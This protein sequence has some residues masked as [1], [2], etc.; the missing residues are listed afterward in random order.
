ME[1]LNSPPVA[2]LLVA[3]V[4]AVV[5]KASFLFTIPPG[6]VSPIFPAAG[7]AIAAVLILGRNALVGVWLGSFAAN[8][9]SFFDGTVSP[10]HAVLPTLLVASFIG[11]GNM[12]GAGAGAFLVRRFC[13][14]EYPLRSGRNVLMLVTV[15]ALGC[16]M[17]NATFGVLSL[18]LGCFVPWERFGYSWITWWMGDATGAI[19][20]APLILAWHH[21]HP[22]HKNLWR[23]T[24][25]A[26]LG[27]VTLLLG[28]FVFFRNMPFAYGLMPL[29]LWAAFRFGMRGASTAAAAIAIFATI[30]TSCGGSPFVR[31]TVNE[32]LLFLHSFLDVT[33]I[34]ALFLAGVLA[35]RKRAEEALRR[36]EATLH[37]VFQSTPVGICIMK[38]RLFQSANVCW[39]ECFGY[40][41]KSILGK[42]TRMLYESDEEYDRVGQALY[43][44]LREGSLAT[45]E[46]RLRRSDG[47]LR[48]VV[49]TAALLRA[50]D[51]AAGIVVTVHDVTNRKRMEESLRKSE[52]QFRLI[53][54]N[55]ADL[56]AV[57]DLNGRRL[58]NSPSYQEILGD[59]DKLRGTSSFDQI[60]PEDRLGVQEAFHE[61]IRTGIGQR[62]EYRM[63][64]R[65]GRPR[66][67]ESQG[68]VIRDAQGRVSQ[69]VV[70]S[71]DITKRKEAERAL[72]ESE[73]KYR[74]LVMLANS[75]ILR[76]S[77]DGRITFLNEFGQRFFGYTQAEI[78]GR[79]V[80]GTIVPATESGGRNLPSLIDQICANPSAFE[81]NVNENVRRNGEHVWI[82]WTNRVVLD[83]RGQ[84]A[85]I[86]SI[87]EDIT[88][89]KRVEEELR[90][91]QATL[92]ERILVRTTELAV[93]RDRAEEADR[94]KS[95]FLATMSHELRTPLNSIIGFTGIILQGLAGPLNAEQIKQLGM[96]RSS[97]RHLLALI[98]DVLDISKIEAGDLKVAFAPF[99]LRATIERSVAAVRP[100]SETKRLALRL[101]I[102]PQIGQLESDARRVEQILLNLLNNAI[103]FT[104]RGGVVLSVDVV[105]STIRMRVT[106]TG[107]GIKSEDLA[108]LFRPFQQVTNGLSR[109]HE[110]TGLGLV[111]CR[112]LAG[113]L[114]G[115]I[116]VESQPGKGS[117]FTVILPR[118]G[119]RPQ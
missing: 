11:I 90:A 97:S 26:V 6:N 43:T 71:R 85:E 8:A 19:V 40:P 87:G 108:N 60:H 68:S 5:A 31:D 113:L 14:D 36:S 34:C 73:Q 83:D 89:R 74:E 57:L 41:E 109:S 39:C 110:G 75:I 30:G 62:L 72:R 116:Q 104:E 79:H 29:L 49:M 21:P 51:P 117:T 3:V 86:L 38:D 54:E 64:G 78:C 25:A 13:K 58:Y 92:E 88:A 53:M 76:W 16:C 27:G 2:V 52:Q 63:M 114:G 23:T 17:V 81:Q 101:E 118:K 82:A 9:I 98:N 46:T 115:E 56:V 20:A 105:A 111:I 28:Y 94:F 112:R 12:A 33:I 47:A 1:T 69:V 42:T 77:R 55:L 93:A 95:A 80:V 32:S 59:P 103:K 61:T 45:A 22:F 50:E 10:V 102:S 44:H 24:E 65:D 119:A 107:I 96:V 37:G 106:D 48:D 84:V 91:A 100:F 7:I 99:D 4:Y 70:V 18:S 67:I 35:E 66:H 15:G